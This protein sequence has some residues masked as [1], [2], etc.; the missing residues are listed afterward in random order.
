MSGEDEPEEAT[1]VTERESVLAERI[2]HAM[3]WHYQQ[4]RPLTLSYYRR[5]SITL[6][7][8]RAAALAFFHL[9]KIPLQRDVPVEPENGT[10]PVVET[11]P[12]HDS[13]SPMLTADQ[14]NSMTYEGAI[15][16]ERLKKFPKSYYHVQEMNK[17]P[18]TFLNQLQV[19]FFSV[20][21]FF[22]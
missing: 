17:G 15:S 20:T 1:N 22:L 7:R 6:L 16:K 9:F 4:L 10:S 3:F 12:T 13:A 2:C 14:I 21:T 5:P 11:P 18:G 19:E 8:R